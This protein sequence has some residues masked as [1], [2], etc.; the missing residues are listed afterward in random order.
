V[1]AMV[2]DIIQS[3]AIRNNTMKIKHFATDSEHNAY[4]Y[5]H[6]KARQRRNEAIKETATIVVAC[7]FGLA[8][9]WVFVQLF[10]GHN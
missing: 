9:V 8:F 3:V 6:I 5:R 2:A 1:V 7:I 10:I 4:T